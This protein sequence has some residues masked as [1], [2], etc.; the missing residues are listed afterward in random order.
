MSQEQKDSKV[1]KLVR[2]FSQIFKDNSGSD[3]K[4]EKRKPVVSMFDKDTQIKL[5]Q[6]EQMISII[7]NRNHG[8]DLSKLLIPIQFKKI[9]IN[10]VD[11]EKNLFKFRFKIIMPDKN[12]SPLKKLELYLKQAEDGDSDDISDE[13]SEIKSYVTKASSSSNSTNLTENS[14]GNSNI[15]SE[16]FGKIGRA[17]V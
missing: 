2:K 15:E 3:A 5:E 4:K 8:S 17:H 13:P 7:K 1:K 10:D 12:T 11:S 14:T 9:L 16:S 6:D